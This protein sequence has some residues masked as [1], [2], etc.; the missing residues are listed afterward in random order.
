MAAI[1]SY[2]PYTKEQFSIIITDYINDIYNGKIFFPYNNY[3]KNN[4]YLEFD[5][6]KILMSHLITD[7]KKFEEFGIYSFHDKRPYTKKYNSSKKKFSM[8]YYNNKPVTIISNDYD[9]ENMILYDYFIE[10]DRM[11]FLSTTDNPT[12]ILRFWENHNFMNMFLKT[13]FIRYNVDNGNP[14]YALIK[15]KLKKLKSKVFRNFFEVAKDDISLFNKNIRDRIYIEYGENKPF[16]IT[17]IMAI[18]KEILPEFNNNSNWLDIS[19]GWGPCLI[20]AMAANV[21]YT[22]IEFYTPHTQNFKEMISNFGDDD[23]HK[24]IFPKNIN[25]LKL[26]ENYDFIL[27]N[28]IYFHPAEVEYGKFKDFFGKK[29]TIESLIEEYYKPLLQNTWKSLKNGGKMILLLEDYKNYVYVDKI[30][31]IILDLRGCNFNGNIYV[32][33]KNKIVKRPIWIFTKS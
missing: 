22:G 33:G 9:Y 4:L 16:K 25:S 8:K 15:T 18:I 12:M 28:L 13:L 31:D 3:N 14:Q 19:V 2:I 23:K 24:I 7:T 6:L 11:T 20:A 32:C 1:K 21:K 5:R 10:K 27:S 26:N 30:L 17:W 29:M